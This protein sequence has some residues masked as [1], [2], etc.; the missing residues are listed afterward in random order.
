MRASSASSARESAA[1]VSCGRQLRLNPRALYDAE[2]AATA[3]RLA[4]AGPAGRRPPWEFDGLEA[5]P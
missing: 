3:A 1:I 5:S 2:K 4:A